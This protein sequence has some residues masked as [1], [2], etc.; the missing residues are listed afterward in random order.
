[1]NSYAHQISAS[2]LVGSADRK[3]VHHGAGDRIEHVANEA[4]LLRIWIHRLMRQQTPEARV[5]VMRPQVQHGKHERLHDEFE[6]AVEIRFAH[7]DCEAREALLDHSRNA[8][9]EDGA[10]EPFLR[11]EMIADQRGRNICGVSELSH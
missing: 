6:P 1:M 11:S 9:L 2:V 4:P 5:S 8:P 3:R 7:C 10:I